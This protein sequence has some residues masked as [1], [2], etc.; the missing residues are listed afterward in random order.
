MRALSVLT[1]ERSARFWIASCACPPQS[2]CYGA[3]RTVAGETVWCRCKSTR[4]AGTRPTASRAIDKQPPAARQ[5]IGRGHGPYP[6]GSAAVHDG[7][8]EFGILPALDLPLGIEGGSH[9][10]RISPNNLRGWLS[11]ESELVERQL[12]RGQIHTTFPYGLEEVHMGGQATGLVSVPAHGTRST[13][14]GLVDLLLWP[15]ERRVGRVPS[16]QDSGAAPRRTMM[17][18]TDILAHLGRARYAN[19][20]L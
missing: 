15:H 11:H 6:A 16:H 9:L 3:H 1:E 10:L 14:A 20:C 18:R 17:C 8:V 19:L 13:H 7:F 4:L 5:G 2:I 12:F